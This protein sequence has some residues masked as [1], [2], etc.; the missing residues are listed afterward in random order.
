MSRTP[1]INTTADA[2]TVF[3]NGEA[4]YENWK[5]IKHDAEQNG[6]GLYML[7][8]GTTVGLATELFLKALLVLESGEFEQVHYLDDL[9]HKLKPQTQADLTAE[10]NAYIAGN[11]PGAAEA[12]ALGIK[13]DL[14]SVLKAGRDCFQKFRYAF[15]ERHSDA[16]F[17]LG[18]VLRGARRKILEAHPDWIERIPIDK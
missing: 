5:L 2:R 14:E 13:T 16:Q 4:F 11:P 10:H 18:S 17:G 7:V 6:E 1:Q 15:D 12:R 3:R 9:F 8:E